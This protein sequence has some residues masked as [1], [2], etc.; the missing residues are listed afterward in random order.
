MTMSTGLLVTYPARNLQL[1]LQSC[2]YHSNSTETK[3]LA[4][5]SGSTILLPDD[6]RREYEPHEHFTR[7]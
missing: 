6:D 3:V 1:Y 7:R 2:S 4:V 5:Q